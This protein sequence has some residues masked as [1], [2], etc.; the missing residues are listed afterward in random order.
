MPTSLEGQDSVNKPC[1]ALDAARVRT[2]LRS[3]SPEPMNLR[4]PV[5]AGTCGPSQ[6]A[7]GHLP[8]V[9]DR[10]SPTPQGR[11]PRTAGVCPG[12]RGQQEGP[13]AGAWRHLCKDVSNCVPRSQPRDWDTAS[14]LGLL[15]LFDSGEAAEVASMA[16]STGLT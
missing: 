4:G 8:A 13:R 16:T 11:S 1:G 5:L 12:L 7:L 3:L 6:E 2:E 14:L 9:T 15:Y 10:T